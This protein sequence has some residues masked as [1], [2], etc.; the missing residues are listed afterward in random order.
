M[1]AKGGKPNTG[2][3]MPPSLIS[4][5]TEPEGGMPAG[6]DERASL[7]PRIVPVALSALVGWRYGGDFL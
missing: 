2:A 7:R 3:A 1:A 4:S 6:L 5:R